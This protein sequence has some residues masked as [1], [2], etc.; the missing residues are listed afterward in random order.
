M[1][2]E[3]VVREKLTERYLLN[4]LDPG[5]RDQFE[6]HFFDCPDCASDVRAGSELL[7]QSKVILAETPEEAFTPTGPGRLKPSNGWFDWLRPAVTAPV[8]A[9]LLLVIL[10]QSLVVYPRLQATLHHPQVMPWASLNVASWGEDRPTITVTEGKN[11]LLLLRIPQ[12]ESYVSYTAD[13]Y[14][15]DGKLVWSLTIPVTSRQDRWPVEVPA[16]NREA[17]SY[18]LDVHGVTSTGNSKEIGKK[19]FE[20][21]I[22]K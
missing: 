22:Q 15:H 12:E 7:A 20:L 19:V 2:H 13:L 18:T 11:F 9:A 1:D 3:V 8:M 17:G 16:A 4:E 21:L 6:E 10:Y 14:N 5:V